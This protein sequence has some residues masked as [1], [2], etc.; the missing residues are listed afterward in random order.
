[1]ANTMEVSVEYTIRDQQR[2]QRASRY[3]LWQASLAMDHLGRR[4]LEVG[5]GVGNF[6]HHLLDRE[7][8]VGLDVVGECVEQ[9]RA[10]FSRNHHVQSKLLDI[11]DPDVVN[12]RTL[13][14]DSVA[15]LNVLEHISDD[16]QALRHMHALLPPGGRAVFIVPAFSSL[17]GPIDRNLGHYRRYS[18]TSWKR[19]ADAAGFREVV[20]NYMNTPGFFGWWVNARILKKTEQS[21]GQIA[22]FDSLI[23]PICSRVERWLKPPFGQSLFAVLERP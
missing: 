13:N 12:L 7:L 18:K 4:V 2:M 14:L 3:F 8:V 15:C 6:T 10:R 23:V 19:L 16:V 17:Y 5:C 1:M 22:V 20:T 9:H 11:L 21:E